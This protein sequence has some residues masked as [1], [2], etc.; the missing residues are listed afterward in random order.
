MRKD[1]A[2]IDK[3]GTHL[4]NADELKQAIKQSSA[5]NIPD[6][7]IDAIIDEVD[8]FGNKKINYTEFLVATMDV[9]RFLDEEKLNALFNQFDTDGS[10]KITKDNIIQ[11]MNKVGHDLTQE[12]LDTIMEQHDLAKDGVISKQEFKALLL[13][14]TDLEDAK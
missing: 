13:D 4:I 7:Q 5:V 2:A 12:E 6:E 14:I 11:A 9:K 3:D 10:G 1:F 8:Y